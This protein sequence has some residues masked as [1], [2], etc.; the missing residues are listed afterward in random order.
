[1]AITGVVLMGPFGCGKT[2]LGRRLADEGIA[3]YEELEPIVY[4]RFGRGFGFDVAA[5]SLFLRDYYFGKLSGADGVTAFESTGVTQRPLLLEVIDVFPVALVRVNTPKEVC[6]A[7][8]AARNVGR[9]IQIK[10][11]RCSDFFDFWTEE[12]A[13]G[14]DFDLEVDGMSPVDAVQAVRDFVRRDPGRSVG[15]RSAIP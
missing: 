4:E 9:E 5:A 2:H 12:V 7:R 3:E 10:P 14:Y 8:V 15:D 13:L 11:S 6:M 1:M